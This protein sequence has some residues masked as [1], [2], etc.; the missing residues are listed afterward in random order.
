MDWNGFEGYIIAMATL[1]RDRGPLSWP[2]LGVSTA[3]WRADRLLVVQR[4]R[5]PM[6]GLWSLPGGLV[7]P[8]ETLAQAAVREVME[9]TG[10][11]ADNPRLHDTMEI[12]RRDDAGTLLTHYVLAIHVARWV[13]GD[14]AA[15]DDAADA[16]WA[17]L[18][19]AGSLPFTPGT[20]DMVRRTAPAGAVTGR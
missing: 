19:E 14:P 16:R 4:G 15:G 7:E 2:L 10:I 1:P 17:T 3:I 5:A 18:D 20:L 8:G 11:V 6:K 12:I 13:R 9:E